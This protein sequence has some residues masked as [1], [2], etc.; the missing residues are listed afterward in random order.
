M[1]IQPMRILDIDYST[2]QSNHDGVSWRDFAKTVVGKKLFRHHRDPSSRMKA[3]QL[4]RQAKIRNK[5]ESLCSLFSAAATA[6]A[7][8]LQPSDGSH[9]NGSEEFLRKNKDVVKKSKMRNRSSSVVSSDGGDSSTVGVERKMAT[10]STHDSIQPL[11]S[12]APPP[13]LSNIKSKNAV[14]SNR[15]A[16]TLTRE[17][18]KSWGILLAKG[19]DDGSKCIVMR[20]P[21]NNVVEKDRKRALN[22]NNKEMKRSSRLRKV[23]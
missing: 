20:A 21:K 8:A 23:M 7:N 1:L 11:S 3:G 19:G 4:R 18:D 6:E 2:D 9:D 22:G 17:T 13:S 14:A 12:P 15:I 5:L 10:P 16:I